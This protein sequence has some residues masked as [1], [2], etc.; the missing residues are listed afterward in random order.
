MPVVRFIILIFCLAASLQ[1]SFAADQSNPDTYFNQKSFARSL[2]LEKDYYRAISEIYRIKF[3]YSNRFDPEL[4]LILIESYYHSELHD[5]VIK[6]SPDLL[7]Q[8]QIP[9]NPG[10]KARLGMFYTASLLDR[11]EASK[12]SKVWEKYC[13]PVSG[14]SFLEGVSIPEPVDPD[15]ARL[16]SAVLP[17]SGFFASGEYGK[18]AVSFLLNAIFIAGAFHYAS[19]QQFGIAGLLVFFELG[20]YFGGQN[21]ASEAA[22][23]YNQKHITGAQKAWIS[24]RI[25]RLHKTPILVPDDSLLQ[26]K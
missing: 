17:G 7:D 8:N 10:F 14:E 21:A 4:D 11:N 19:E 9:L 3:I 1:Y 16:Y 22:E 18:G 20:W 25:N 26:V 12:A 15:K 6:S 24:D 13:L 2:A 5:R 23:N